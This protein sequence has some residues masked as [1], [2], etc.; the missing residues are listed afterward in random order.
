M[1]AAS[2]LFSAWWD[3]RFLPLLAASFSIN[4]AAGRAIDAAVSK[5]RQSAA[6]WWMTA[7]I[8]LNLGVLALFKYANFVLTNVNSVIGTDFTLRSIILL[9]GISFSPSSRSASSSIAAVP[10]P[11][12]AL[13][14]LRAVR[15]LLP[16]PGCR[17]DPA[18]QRDRPQSAGARVR[19]GA[20]GAEL[21]VGLTLFSIG[22]VKKSLLADGIAPYA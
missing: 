2:L 1:L 10:D 7:A 11:A 9:L 19:E 20:A 17:P 5:G 15:L 16:A 22:L 4:Y 3:I 13:Q 14:A 18:L 8:A 12:D 6:G 21:A